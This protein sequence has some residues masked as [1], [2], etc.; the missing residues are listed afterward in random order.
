MM[1]AKGH[2][3]RAQH[4][5]VC[6]KHLIQNAAQAHAVEGA[7]GG[8]PAVALKTGAYVDPKGRHA[9]DASTG[10]VQA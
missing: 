8:H 5:T 2:A 7:A 10:I 9:F 1:S 3:R 4:F 6:A